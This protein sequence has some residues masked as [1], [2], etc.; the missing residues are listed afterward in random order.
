VPPQPVAADAET[1]TALD[2]ARKAY[3]AAKGNM[4]KLQPVGTKLQEI[5]VKAPNDP[6]ALTL[7]AQVQLEQ[8]KMEDSLET[9]NRCTEVAPTSAA[10]W[11]TIGVFQETKG[12]DEIAKLAY[13]K[14]LALAPDG[15]YANDA[16]KAL[17]RLK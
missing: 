3:D 7:M 14:Y 10:C 17:G 13:Q 8:G 11:L 12:A 5:L 15:R 16:R 1:K 2:E 9:S 4:R 6:D